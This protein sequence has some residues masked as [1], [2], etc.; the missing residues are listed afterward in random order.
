MD[1]ENEPQIPHP[2]ELLDEIEIPDQEPTPPEIEEPMPPEAPEPSPP[3]PTPETPPAQE[4]TLAQF[5][6][7]PPEV[8]AQIWPTI[9]ATKADTSQILQFVK[10][11]DGNGDPLLPVLQQIVEICIRIEQKMDGTYTPPH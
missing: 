5:Q 9:Q 6:S 11:G 10:P 7:L 2:M 8:Q 3:A 1:Y 4:M